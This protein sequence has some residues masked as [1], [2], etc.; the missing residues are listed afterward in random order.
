[1]TMEQNTINPL[2]ILARLSWGESDDLE[3]KSAKGGLPRSLWETYSA[4]ANTRGGVILLGVQDDGT[5][6]GIHDIVKIKNDFWNTINNCGK[7]S[8]NLLNHNDVK[9][10]THPNGT[11]L[12]IRIR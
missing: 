9:E 5:I 11:I 7:V 12:A 8:V 2:D 1:M 4:M 3:F 6:S 10:I